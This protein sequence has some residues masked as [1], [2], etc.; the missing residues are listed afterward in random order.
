MAAEPESQQKE[1]QAS[2][3]TQGSWETTGTHAVQSLR[4]LHTDA[5]SRG[6]ARATDI[7]PRK[8][9]VR[10]RKAKVSHLA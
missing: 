2:A 8:S 4:R 1:A 9:P 7:S 10:A 6:Q 3:R 5:E